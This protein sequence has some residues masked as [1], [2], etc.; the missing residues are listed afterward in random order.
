MRIKFL[1]ALLAII[2]TAAMADDGTPGGGSAGTNW[3]VDLGLADVLAPAY[4]GA[5]AYRNHPLPAVSVNYDER[6]FFSLQEGLRVA[7]LDQDGLTAGPMLTFD[8]GRSTTADHK[9]LDSLTD[10]TPSV[11]AGGFVNYD[12]GEVATARVQI[13]KAFGGSKGLEARAGLAFKAPPL[14]DDTLFLS[15]GPNVTFYDRNYSR[16]YFG[17]S[18][19]DALRS[20]YRAFKPNDGVQIGLA[21]Y[22]AYLISQNISLNVFGA[23]GKYTGG[24][25]HS[26]ILHGQYGTTTQF[27]TGTTLTYRFNF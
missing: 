6:V 27:A 10:V 14:F 15:A 2:P 8:F 18:D 3:H 13:T 17:V 20:G 12:F 4:P 11:A 23:F 26:P 19:A 24:I 16:A 21:A 7:V 9:A 25:V 1:L 5:K 22:A